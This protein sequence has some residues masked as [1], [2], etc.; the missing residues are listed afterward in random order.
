M[1]ARSGLTL[2]KGTKNGSRIRP[3]VILGVVSPEDRAH[4]ATTVDTSDLP[5]DYKPPTL[6]MSKAFY[7]RLDEEL[8]R[9]LRCEIVADTAADLPPLETPHSIEGLVMGKAPT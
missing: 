3:V 9:H 2:H 8:K 6:K 7:D 5:T 4:S 1:S